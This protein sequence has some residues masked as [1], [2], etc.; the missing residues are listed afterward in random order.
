MNLKFEAKIGPY[1]TYSFL[2]GVKKSM[3]IKDRK[4]PEESKAGKI[5]QTLINVI[6]AGPEDLEPDQ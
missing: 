2:E 5:I 4:A 6:F 1:R 3:A